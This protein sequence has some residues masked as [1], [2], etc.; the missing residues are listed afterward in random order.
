MIARCDQCVYWKHWH[1]GIGGQC[2]RFAS[3]EE[4]A[5]YQILVAVL[6]TYNPQGKGGAPPA[7][8]VTAPDFG[9]TEF[10]KGESYD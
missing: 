3:E 5:K 7:M 2:R 6:H 9:C 10:Y 4:G 8:L 1:A